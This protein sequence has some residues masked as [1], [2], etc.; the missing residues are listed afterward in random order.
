LLSLVSHYAA[1]AIDD[2]FNFAQ[3]ELVRAQLDEEK[4]QAE[5]DPGSEQQRSF[6]S[7]AAAMFFRPF[8]GH[9]KGDASG[10]GGVDLADGEG[11]ELQLYALDFPEGNLSA[12]H[13]L[14]TPLNGSVSGRVFRNRQTW[15]GT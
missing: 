4:N 14:P 13:D 3:S 2:R 5:T 12:R 10:W 6:Q 15:V 1:L 9:S 7:R 8:P 11:R